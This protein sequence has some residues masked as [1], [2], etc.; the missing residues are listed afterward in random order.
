[1]R[2][3]FQSLNYCGNSKPTSQIYLESFFDTTLD[4]KEICLMPRK[5]TVD[6][7]TSMFQYQ[8]ITVFYLN[9]MLFVYKKSYYTT[10]LF[11]KIKR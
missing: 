11:L 2:Q 7:F 10:M 6:T 8:I 4:W 3:F 9:K 5:V 1:M